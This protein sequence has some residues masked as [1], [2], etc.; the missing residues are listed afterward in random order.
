[1]RTDTVIVDR[2]VHASILE[3]VRLG[4]GKVRRFRHNDIESLRKN[5]EAS[6]DSDGILVIVDGV[7][8]ME[9]DIA[10]LPEI[11]RHG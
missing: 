6:A 1:M 11:V 3:G 8:S 9:G 2:L 5:L 7:Y 10:P 4:F